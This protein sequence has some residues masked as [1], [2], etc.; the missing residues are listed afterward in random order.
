[1]TK[2]DK[3]ILK[4]EFQNLQQVEPVYYISE[5]SIYYKNKIASMKLEY[6]THSVC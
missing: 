4:K 2:I 3:E 6:T 1:M 5:N